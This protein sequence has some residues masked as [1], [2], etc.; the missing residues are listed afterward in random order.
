MQGSTHQAPRGMMYDPNHLL[1][2]Q[3]GSAGSRR[4]GQI[5]KTPQYNNQKS[6]SQ[7]QGQPKGSHYEHQQHNE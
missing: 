3:G 1:N 6:N 7:S 2:Q 5:P 4:T